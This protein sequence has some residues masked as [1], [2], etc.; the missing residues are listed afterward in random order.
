MVTVFGVNPILW[1]ALASDER[2]CCTFFF[3]LVS[4]VNSYFCM[5]ML[6]IKVGLRTNA[7]Y[8]VLHMNKRMSTRYFL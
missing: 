6:T 1:A 4:M 5:W 7:C 8:S 2:S 3:S